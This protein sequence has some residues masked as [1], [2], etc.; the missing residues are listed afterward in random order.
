[1]YTQAPDKKQTLP[2]F[3]SRTQACN[4]RDDDVVVTCCYNN[5]LDPV[6]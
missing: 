6:L 3:Y 5:D 1:M 4:K 2:L